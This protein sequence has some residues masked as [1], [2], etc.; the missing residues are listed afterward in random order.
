MK[1]AK[2]YVGIT[3]GNR[4]MFVSISIPTEKNY[5]WYSAVIGPFKTVRAAKWCVNHQYAQCTTVKEF[6]RAALVHQTQSE[7]I[8]GYQK[9]LDKP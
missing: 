6:E 3:N 9:H 4:E 7:L 1:R 8:A 5:P 2:I